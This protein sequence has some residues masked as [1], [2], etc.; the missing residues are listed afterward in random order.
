[1]AP[2][3]A[4]HFGAAHHRNVVPI[5][6]SGRARWSRWPDPGMASV[7]SNHRS[8]SGPS[9]APLAALLEPGRGRPER[10]ETASSFLRAFARCGRLG[11]CRRPVP[12]VG[13]WCR[14]QLRAFLRALARCRRLEICGRL[15]PVV[16][17]C[18]GRGQ[19]L[20]ASSAATRLR[21]ALEAAPAPAPP[22][23]IWGW[24][25]RGSRVTVGP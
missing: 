1:M 5:F 4:S 18:R 11:V 8:D 10:Y 21:H 3:V 12:V 20:A 14:C 17:R 24:C 19:P 6:A 25:P 15:L 16:G 13:R 9:D 22:R 23:D 7:L 2:P